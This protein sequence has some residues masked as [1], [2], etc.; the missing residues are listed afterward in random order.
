MDEGEARE[1]GEG[2]GGEG[3]RAMDRHD[4]ALTHQSCCPT[5]PLNL[6]VNN[7]LRGRA[8][9][10]YPTVRPASAEKEGGWEEE[11]ARAMKREDAPS[12]QLRRPVAPSP[13][14]PTKSTNDGDGVDTQWATVRRS[15]AARKGGEGGE[16]VRGK[17]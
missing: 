2:R 16:D 15:R 12:H 7:Q 4:D 10:R 17:E 13:P 9:T 6:Q 8:G 3:V 14:R 11:G 5:P 1:G